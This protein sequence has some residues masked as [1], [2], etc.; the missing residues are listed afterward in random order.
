MPF[1]Y[2]ANSNGRLSWVKDGSCLPYVMEQLLSLSISEVL[3]SGAIM[4]ADFT[5]SHTELKSRA[6]VLLGSA[7]APKRVEIMMPLYDELGI[8]ETHGGVGL[9]YKKSADSRMT[10]AVSTIKTFLSS[11][12]Q[13]IEYQAMVNIDILGVKNAVATLTSIIKHSQGR[14]LLRDINNILDS[15]QTMEVNIFFVLPTKIDMIPTKIHYATKNSIYEQMVKEAYNL[16]IPSN[17]TN[18]VH[19]LNKL[20]YEYR[21][22]HRFEEFTNL[23]SVTISFATRQIKRKDSVIFDC[24]ASEAFMPPIP[25]TK[26]MIERAHQNWWKTEPEF[27]SIAGERNRNIISWYDEKRIRQNKKNP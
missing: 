24:I 16:G 12:L 15:Y 17:A 26:S 20:V 4:S 13:A 25:I 22:Q 14:H 7:I 23:S 11:Y 6:S 8:E 5:R 18:A 10:S 9:T 3:F 2:E 1:R 19:R 21:N 27:M